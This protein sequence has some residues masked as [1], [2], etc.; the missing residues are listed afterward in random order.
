VVGTLRVPRLGARFAHDTRERADYFVPPGRA[1]RYRMRNPYT[2]F[3]MRA[4]LA[5]LLP[6]AVVCA[7][8]AARA[9]DPAPLLK[10]VAPA[11]GQ[12]RVRLPVEPGFPKTM[13]F[14][15]QVPNG[16][17]KSELLDVTV[18]LDTLPGQSYITA[19]K[20]ESWG[21]AVPKGKEFL[22]P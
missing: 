18:A 19:K 4:R 6:A 20:L 22:L 21:Y 12:L 14:S 8:L 11:G 13:R 3:P 16:K 10:P 7:A 15:A 2:R 9:D 1:A 17:K 5:V